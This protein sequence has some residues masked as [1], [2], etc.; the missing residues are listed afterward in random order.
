MEIA[1]GI[2]S[3]TKTTHP[4]NVNLPSSG[5]Q[6]T[7]RLSAREV[8][9]ARGE[10]DPSP[11]GQGRYIKIWCQ[12]VWGVASS[13]ISVKIPQQSNLHHPA[14]SFLAG[15]L[16][17]TSLLHLPGLLGVRLIKRDRGAYPVRRKRR[18]YRACRRWEK[19][20]AAPNAQPAGLRCAPATI[21]LC[22][23]SV[24]YLSATGVF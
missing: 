11:P 23:R 8:S 18:L 20:R 21:P 1:G 15:H 22:V 14:S 6:V 5:Q 2:H 16:N 13:S 10:Q 7:A 9:V 4:S 19:Q 3:L 24:R 17:D 12:C